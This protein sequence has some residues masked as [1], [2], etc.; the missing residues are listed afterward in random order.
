MRN[1]T[2]E[3]VKKAEDSRIAARNLRTASTSQKNAALGS[4]SKALRSNEEL[5]IASNQKDISL[6]KSKGLDG[7]V[8]ARL[9]LTKEKLQSMV[10]GI[11][12]VIQLPDPVGEILESRTLPNGIQLEKRRVPLGVIGTIFE[13]RPEVP[14]DIA[15][16]CIKSGNSVVMRGGSEAQ[17]TNLI[18]GKLIANALS[19]TEIPEHSV[20]M[21]S[22]AD[23]M[24]VHDMI[25]MDGY[26]D[27]II[28][29]GGANL[30]QFV[31]SE[32]TVPAITGG[33]GVCHIYLDASVNAEMATRII[34]NS[35]VQAPSVCNALDTV[36]INSA[37]DPA[38]VEKVCLSLINHGVEL[39][40]DSRT[41]SLLES[42]DQEKLK[43]ASS[44]D[45]GQE[46]L[47]LIASFRM[48]DSMN[49]AIQ[50]IE[51]HGSGHSEAII[52][53]DVNNGNQFTKDVDA[54]L[55]LVNAST[56]FNDGGQIGL[57]SEVAISTGKLHARGP[58]GLRELTSYKWVALGAGQ[59]RD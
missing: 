1:F 8:L 35:K 38:I 51:T 45:Y 53:N 57:G 47:N 21:L 54:A 34:V 37:I 9:L 56:R 26:F 31:A 32:A 19:E 43:L 24:L 2:P 39:R 15:S 33:I 3:I 18:L 7:A 36:L 20:Q 28:P 59:I 29:R 5:I 50:H 25:K 10:A 4:I 13:A 40:C 46:F 30:I 22:S 49:E 44:K 52:T 6:A 42:L 14:V 48:V 12:R 55:V 17:S 11:E 27:L 16:L 41:L 23:R 58:M